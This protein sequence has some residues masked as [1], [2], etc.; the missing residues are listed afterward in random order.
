MIEILSLT[1]SFGSLLLSLRFRSHSESVVKMS[2]CVNKTIMST[3]DYGYKV[4][5]D[6]DEGVCKTTARIF[7]NDTDTCVVLAFVVCEEEKVITILEGQWWRYDH[8]GVTHGEDMPEDMWFWTVFVDAVLKDVFEVTHPDFDVRIVNPDE[9]LQMRMRYLDAS[10]TATEVLQNRLPGHVAQTIAEIGVPSW[11]Q[12]EY[13]ADATKAKLSACL[14]VD[15]DKDD[16]FAVAE[17]L[18]FSV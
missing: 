17:A 14:P 7:D 15:I 16:Y 11:A 9:W 6:M 1:P 10:E 8:D 3:M 12:M 2:F 5:V 13:S 18:G 4:V